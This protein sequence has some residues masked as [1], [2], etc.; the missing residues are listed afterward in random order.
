MPQA[1]EP[2]GDQHFRFVQRGGD[3]RSTRH[4]TNRRG[5]ALTAARYPQKLLS[6]YGAERSIATASA[7][8]YHAC[9]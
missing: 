9:G 3:R 6:S 1:P 2:S 7:T 4:V 5:R 8:E